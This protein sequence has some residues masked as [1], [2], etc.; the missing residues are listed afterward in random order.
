M[1]PFSRPL[2][3]PIRSTRANTLV[4]VIA[5]VVMLGLAGAALVQQAST[6]G[7]VAREANSKIQQDSFSAFQEDFAATAN[8]DPGT[9]A[10]NPVQGQQ[11]TTTRTVPNM[12]Q[13][14][15]LVT[16]AQPGPFL[17]RDSQGK[18]IYGPGTPAVYQTVWV[19]EGTR[20]EQTT[21][22]V[23]MPSMELNSGASLELPGSARILA[24]APPASSE[25]KTVAFR[26]ATT[27]AAVGSTSATPLNP[28][29]FNFSGAVS[30]SVFLAN[31][32]LTGFLTPATNPTGTIVRYTTD[33]SVPTTT[34]PAW[35]STSGFP[36][37]LP[38][39]TVRAAA[40]HADSLWARSAIA[41]TTLSRRIS[42]SYAREGGGS[43]SAFT[44]TQ[45][46]GNT[47]RIVLSTSN[48][49]SGSQ[50][51]YT[52]DGSDPT[53]SSPAYTGP[54]HVGFSGWTSAGVTLKTTVFTPLS[55]ITGS[56]SINQLM[57]S[58]IPLPAPTFGTATS[59]AAGITLPVSLSGIPSG[60]ARIR[61]AINSTLSASS[62]TV[63][64]GDSIFVPAP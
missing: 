18:P 52:L 23:G 11:V 57:P 53:T 8:V 31:P 1:A 20:D 48:P 46:N 7:M 12:V 6:V 3:K 10:S 9:L 43:S 59:S 51:R 62:P 56:V 47:A 55:N 29:T 37:Y 41:E 61:Y 60:W 2:S 16:L 49:P 14:Q 35:S 21:T 17:G 4:S 63:A 33:G 13:R 22:T 28:P 19:Q 27:A 32:T 40:F 58:R 26:I 15:V 42:V 39:S 38:P 24:Y 54:F 50:I 64:P 25:R 45:I 5:G 30:E 34:S 44:F 36:A